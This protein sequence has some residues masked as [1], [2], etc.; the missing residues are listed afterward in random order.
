[1][2]RVPP[3][4]EAFDNPLRDKPKLCGRMNQMSPPSEPTKPSTQVSPSQKIHDAPL[5]SNLHPPHRQP[6]EGWRNSSSREWRRGV[7]SDAVHSQWGYSRSPSDFA[8]FNFAALE[9][10]TC[11]LAAADDICVACL[12]NVDITASAPRGAIFKKI[13]MRS[14]PLRTG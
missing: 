14:N 7:A 6:E 3:A 11:V 12:P 1:M 10:G 13:T 5:D 9:D 4:T 2:D 8:Q